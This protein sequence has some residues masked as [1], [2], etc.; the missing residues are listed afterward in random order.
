MLTLIGT[1]HIAK[2]SIDIITKS[3]EEIEPDII[4]IEL[5]KQRLI[6]LISQ[7]KNQ[8]SSIEWSSMF[9]IGL[10]GFFFMLL[11]H[12]VEHKL[13]SMVGVKPGADMLQGYTLAKKHQKELAFIDQDIRVT[14]KRLSKAI[15][16]KEKG[17]FVADLF[18][19]FVLKQKEDVGEFD[20][21]KV[22]QK[23]IIAKLLAKTKKRYPNIYKTL[24]TER[25]TVM[26]KNI[27][28]LM[29]EYPDKKIM[30]I[31]GAGHEKEIQK[32]VEKLLSKSQ[33]GYSITV[34]A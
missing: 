21:S 29:L 30:A 22:P 10:N 11:G 34:D 4:A 1:S 33:A 32:L 13:G 5:D 2:E 14:L 25:N 7:S 3:Y 15:S 18:K 26:A 31:I 9:K 20:L 23:D 16:W 12:W 8:K 24:V 17:N 28:S 27:A 6:S 19:G